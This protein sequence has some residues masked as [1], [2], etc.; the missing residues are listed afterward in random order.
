MHSAV[1]A[2][3]AA[4]LIAGPTVLAFFSGGYFDRPRLIAGLLAWGAV[5]AAVL[6]A[7][8]PL[9]RGR[10]G[11]IALAGLAALCA[12]T[13]ISL[14]WT[15]I[16]GA[17]ADDLQ[18]LL[19]FVA[20]FGACT[21]LFRAL[22]VE[23]VLE[24][25]LA[26]GTLVV[27][28]Y[29]LSE[30]LVPDLVELS[31]SVT[32]GGRLEQPLTYWNA[33]GALA[34]IGLVLCVRLV[35]DT[36]RDA[37]LRAASA[38]AAVPLAAGV[39]LSLSRG[40]FAALALG[41]AVLVALAPDGRAQLRAV[42]MALVT[43]VPA[44]AVAG[45]LPAV[46][47]LGEG[48][49]ARRAQGLLMLAVL[50]G[51]AALGAL[52]AWR[53]ARSQRAPGGPLRGPHRALAT[54]G[55]ASCCSAPSWPP[56]R[57]SLGPSRAA[58]RSARTPS[59]SSRSTR[60]ATPTGEWHST[61]SRSG[62]SRESAPV[63]SSWSGSST[64]TWTIRRASRTRST[65]ARLQSWGSSGF[66]ALL[67]LLGGV[68]AAARELWR[69]DPALATGPVAA[70]VLWAAHAGIDWDWRCPPSRLWHSRSPARSS[71]GRTCPRR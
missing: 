58:P 50:V 52:L 12:W 5:L 66:A 13:A 47:T 64:A 14:L 70:L 31:H 26:A 51:L 33:S 24:P 1:A 21:L 27:T 18:R 28:G 61:P 44:A 60:T 55:V 7:R 53:E 56:R 45:A 2:T 41:L 9:P 8:Q 43:G 48:A 32:A 38:A 16:A 10:P 49:G 68:A 42:G 20:Y 40:V 11:R 19:L 65:S 59:G 30:R 34:A 62:R 69:R 39:Y 71:R 15:P 4:L 3:L 17:T 23:R 63:R 35:G 29:A 22:W 46:R 67:A 36:S 25:A 54:A 37:K 6:L 57:S